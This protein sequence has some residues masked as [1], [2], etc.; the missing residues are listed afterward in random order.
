MSNLVAKKYDEAYEIFTKILQVDPKNIDAMERRA[1]IHF[2]K[3]E[4]EECVIECAEILRIRQS[5]DIKL[6]MDDAESKIGT[7]EDWFAVLHVSK[8][9]DKKDVEKAYRTLAKLFSPNAKKNAKKSVVDRE[10]LQ[11]KMARINKAK[12]HYATL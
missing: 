12:T 6:L 1:E 3:Q 5:N 10:K 9:A 11:R 7:E 4:F 2:A 8:H